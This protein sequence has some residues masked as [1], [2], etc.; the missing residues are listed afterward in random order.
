M[1]LRRIE[2]IP[3]AVVVRECEAR[4]RRNRRRGRVSAHA[5]EVAHPL[6]DLT[7][8]EPRNPPHEDGFGGAALAREVRDEV[9]D[10]ALNLRDGPGGWLRAERE[11]KHALQA[12]EGEGSALCGGDGVAR[13]KVSQRVVPSRARGVPILGVARCIALSAAR[14]LSGRV[15]LLKPHRVRR[16]SRRGD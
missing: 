1:G 12:G 4:T 13:K 16:C 9:R 5:R 14:G 7:R 3:Q 15:E 11:R 10:P 6:R 2:L 8:A